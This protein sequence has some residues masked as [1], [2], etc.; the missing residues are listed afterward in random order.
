MASSNDKPVNYSRRFFWLLLGIV[1]AIALYSGGWYYAAGKVGER[2][3]T[4][5]DGANASGRRAN[6]ESLE[7]RGYPFRLGVFCRSVMF[8]DPKAA[9][10][11][12][13]GAFRSAAQVYQPNLVIGELDGPATLETPGIPT[14]D[15]KWESM[16]A[17]VRIA[18]PLPERVSVEGRNVEVRLDEP[19]DV[20]PLLGRAGHAELHARPTADAGYD[21]AVRFNELRFDP[22]F[23]GTDKLSPLAGLADFF[24]ERWQSGGRESS[25]NIRNLTV[26]IDDKGSGAEVSGPFAVGI[27]GL[28][29]AEL[30]VK[31]RNP[32]VLGE[33]LVSLMPV[34]REQV[35]LAVGTIAMLGEE[36]TFPL[37]ISRGKVR[38][39]FVSLGAIPPLF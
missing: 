8:E 33:L 17:S 26:S 4:A 29:D 16:R 31:V 22:N 1:A 9:I 21:L 38:I 35:E 34:Y 24:V 12:Q 11:F 6:C 7:V 36:P 32:R 10:R 39:G 2:V 37:K 3:Q 13:A 30:Q 18:S 20:P 25:V 23:V 5:V 14:L 15:L 28:I 27:D 19:G